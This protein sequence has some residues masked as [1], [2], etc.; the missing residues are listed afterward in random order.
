VRLKP[1]ITHRF[2]IEQAESAYALMMEGS[3]PYIAM[4]IT[5][6]SDRARP[7]PRTIAV[8]TAQAA[9][10]VTLGIIGAGNHVR[11]MLLPPLQN[12]NN[13]GIRGICTA[14][15]IT[16]KTLAGKITAAYC[17]SDSQSILD[18]PAI[19]TVLIGTRHDSHAAL[20]VRHCSRANMCS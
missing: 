8:G 4:V 6:P 12:M 2:P 5:Y 17:T 19:N 18:D 10:P 13:V 3:T 11:D 9:R 20:T 1:L 16:A 14:S 15:G 7:L